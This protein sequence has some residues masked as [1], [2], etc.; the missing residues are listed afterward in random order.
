[1]RR[2]LLAAAAASLLL[3]SGLTAC[4]GDEPAPT[5]TW[6]VGYSP[7]PTPTPVE[8]TPSVD[9]SAQ[10]S[11]IGL[12]PP[13]DQATRASYLAD[14]NRID[15]DIIHGR[16]DT[17]VNRGRDQC[18][19]VKATPTNQAVLI[20]LTNERFTSPTHPNGFGTTKALEILLVV[21]RHLCPDL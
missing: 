14:L 2:S 13:P 15:P 6:T 3:L 21:R 11:Q 17:A 16:P 12:P 8:T 10:E 1:M 9:P 7:S 5:P 20:K 19:A 4:D 18:A